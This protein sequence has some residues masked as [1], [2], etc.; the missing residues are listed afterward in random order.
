M[1]QVLELGLIL[2]RRRAYYILTA[3]LPACILSGLNLMV[4]FVPPGSGEKMSLCIS[5][6]L[7]YAVYLTSINSFL[8]SVSDH[9]ALF[10]V[11]LHCMFV[12]KALTV[13]ASVF[14]LHL[15]SALPKSTI[16]KQLTKHLSPKPKKYIPGDLVSEYCS[17]HN[18][19]YHPVPV[20]KSILEVSVNF[21]L[22][23]IENLDESKQMLT[24]TGWF[25]FTWTLEGLSWD[26]ANFQNISKVPVSPKDFWLPDLVLQNANNNYGRLG[27]EHLP[28]IIRSNGTMEWYAIDRRSTS[29]AIDVTSFPFDNQRC[30][31]QLLQWITTTS[32]V[33]YTFGNVPISYIS[34]K[35]NG[36]WEVLGSFI[37]EYYLPDGMYQ[38][39][40]LGLILARRRA[41]YIL[42]A[43][44]PACILSGLNLMVFHVPPGSG[45]KMTLCVSVLLAYAVYL[46]SINSFLPSVSDHVALFSIYLHCMFV[47]KALTVM[48]TVFVLHLYS[49]LPKSTI[50][51]QLTKHLS[52][53]PKKYTPDSSF[54]DNLQQGNSCSDVTVKPS[55]NVDD[56]T[57]VLHDE[58]WGELVK[59]VDYMFFCIFLLLFILSTVG[60]FCAIASR[61]E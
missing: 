45:E 22:L 18:P 11:Y 40:E 15:H 53:R 9:V 48:A 34:Y 23:H 39:L 38:V 25:F 41:Y 61:Q 51:K 50:R 60:V 47:L 54:T 56:V 26:E 6:L 28:G 58:Q 55:N 8:P 37:E 46:A 14:V 12:L 49:A 17:N 19:L 24:T 57:H 7:A 52:P 21:N 13:V 20:S 32:E 44:L 59:K 16:R 42:T 10:S 33:N 3:V 4:F 27:G 1:Y 29:C 2:A 30:S 43:V 31:F 35:D 5:V 36:E